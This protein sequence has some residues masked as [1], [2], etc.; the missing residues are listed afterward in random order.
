MALRPR[1]GAFA[2]LWVL[3]F[4]AGCKCDTTQVK[5]TD[6][7]LGVTGAQADRNGTC[8]ANDEC[9]DHFG[10]RDVKDKEGVKCCVFIDRAC[11]TEADC[12]PGQTC[13]ADRKKC[14]DKFLSCTVDADCGD[15]G[16]RVCEVYTD[17]Y[18]SSSRCRFRTCGPLGECP[19]GQ[20]CFQGECM[21]GLPCGGACEPGKACVPSSDRCQDYAMPTGRPTAACPVSCAPGF[22]ATFAD[23]RNLW[24]ACNLPPV[25]CACAELP[26]LVSGDL[27]R[28][29]ALAADPGKGLYVSAYDGQFGDLVVLKYG[30]D[31]KRQAVEYVD[32]VPSGAPKFGPSGA[33]GGVD[34]L[35]PDVGRYT[36]IAVANGRVY[37][38]YYDVTNGDLKVAVRKPDATWTSHRVDGAGG[39][40]GLY[41][42]I[43]VDADGAPG[44]SY[45]QLGGDAA[46]NVMDCPA[47][48]PTGSVKYITA[49]KF[50]RATTP[51][52]ASDGD[53]AVKTL[54]CLSRP[55]PTCEGCVGLC[56][57]PGM[58]PGCFN[59][60]TGCSGC[61]PSTE[62]C[63]DVNGTSQCAKKFTPPA[64]VETPVG[65]GLFSSL[66]FDGKDAIIA[67]LRRNP[68]VMAGG[69]ADGDLY[70]VRVSAQNTPSAPVLLDGSGDT[71]Y[72][73]DVKLEPA[74][75]SI[76][77]G[78][79]DFT[80]KA[81]KFYFAPQLQA[82]VTPE[83]IDTGVDA[84]APG[85]QSWV[86]TD[87]AIV[88]GPSPGQV[89]A[90]YQ[91]PTKGDLKIARRTASWQVQPSLATEGAV[92]F[93][94][95]GVFTDGKLYATHARLK[96]RLVQGE[97]KVANALLLEQASGN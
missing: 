10:C 96:A 44:V 8:S 18:G 65:V 56:A 3:A 86:G 63:V 14:F 60:G 57:D 49:L 70:A 41:T 82:G 9:A 76:A 24:D 35:G 84:T 81:F 20:S 7:C 64:L 34:Q 79:H 51:T 80:S 89:W 69:T 19:E 2:A 42:S 16:D 93:F 71:G 53:W 88:F 67:Y 13:P 11:T 39:N 74:T 4:V 33:R 37:V 58:G 68:P 38:S 31:G 27:A 46:F 28:F 59:A 30:L 25:K 43:A 45:F 5:P 83:L 75:R 52:P 12:C 22:L 6:V 87:S 55:P 15:K 21:A 23:A 1:S 61:D 66:T 78:Y 91:D 90:V 48:R 47:P 94:A 29:S 77:I 95:D 73:P 72:F 36:D 97:A 54:A 26:G 85:N 62:A 92:G 50:A 17:T 40:L 32:G